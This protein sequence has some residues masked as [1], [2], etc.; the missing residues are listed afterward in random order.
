MPFRRFGIAGVRLAQIEC[1]RC[2]LPLLFASCLQPLVFTIAGY[3]PLTIALSWARYMIRPCMRAAH[4]HHQKRLRKRQPNRHGPH[5]F[6]SPTRYLL[7]MAPL[8]LPEPLLMCWAD[9]I[10]AQRL[11]KTRPARE[12]SQPQLQRAGPTQKRPLKEMKSG[13]D[14]WRAMCTRNQVSNCMT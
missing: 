3:D 12:Q 2:L 9:C 11:R 4:R 8:L 7:M 13:S 1:S 10:A 5:A 14:H 6:Q